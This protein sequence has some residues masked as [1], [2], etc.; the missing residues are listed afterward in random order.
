MKTKL[1]PLT[2]IMCLYGKNWTDLLKRDQIHWL[3]YFRTV[4]N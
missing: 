4:R 2:L 3:D 1:T